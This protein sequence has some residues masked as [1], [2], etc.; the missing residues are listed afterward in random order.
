MGIMKLSRQ[1]DFISIGEQRRSSS[2]GVTDPYSAATSG[3]SA[4]ISDSA[5]SLS[6]QRAKQNFTKP[7]SARWVK[8]ISEMPFNNSTG[9]ASRSIFTMFKLL[10][11]ALCKASIT[12]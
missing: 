12:K 5:S 3:I 1:G 9:S 4:D 11:T 2:L 6:R 10:A 7:P 8:P